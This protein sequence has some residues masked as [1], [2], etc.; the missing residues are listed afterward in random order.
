[1]K[2][3][4]IVTMILAAGVAANAVAAAKGDAKNG[5]TVYMQACMGCHSS[6][7]AGAPKVGDKADWKARSKQGMDVLNEHAIKGYQGKGGFMPAKGGRMDLS[8]Q[9]VIDAVAYMVEASK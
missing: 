2:K 3:I 4:A 1:M 7:A 8:D 6:G 5:K 9:A